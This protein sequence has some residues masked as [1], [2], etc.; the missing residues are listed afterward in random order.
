MDQANSLE[1]V[2]IGGSNIYNLTFAGDVKGLMLVNVNITKG[3]QLTGNLGAFTFNGVNWPSLEFNTN[4][5]NVLEPSFVFTDVSFKQLDK[6]DDLHNPLDAQTTNYT[7]VDAYLSALD[8]ALSNFKSYG[9]LSVYLQ[10]AGDSTE[11]QKVFMHEKFFEV[12]NNLK[13]DTAYLKYQKSFKNFI[14]LVKTVFTSILFFLILFF[15]A[16][17]QWSYIWVP[18]LWSVILLVTGIFWPFRKNKMEFVPSDE[19]L[20]KRLNPGVMEV[21]SPFWYALDLYLPA[22]NLYAETKWQ[23]KTKFGLFYARIL[24]L[25]GRF[26][27]G[28]L[29]VAWSGIIK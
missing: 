22:V 2:L 26:M 13:K 16:Y 8:G 15:T 10:N 29:F 12:W 18:V 7:A 21:Y 4:F 28:V 23:P 17:G 9:N 6:I 19:N 14:F 25:L 5:I 11:A 1:Y 27:L 20:L 3:A 24:K